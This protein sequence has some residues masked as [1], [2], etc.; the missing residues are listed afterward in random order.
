MTNA[1]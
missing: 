1:H